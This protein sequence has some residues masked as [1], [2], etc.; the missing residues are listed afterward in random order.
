MRHCRMPALCYRRFFICGDRKRTDNGNDR[1]V[2]EGGLPRDGNLAYGNKYPL[3]LYR[4]TVVLH[5]L[6]QDVRFIEDPY[7]AYRRRKKSDMG[8]TF[9]R[10]LYNRY[11][12]LDMGSCHVHDPGSDFQVYLAGIR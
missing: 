4:Y 2:C 12:C 1:I 9:P 6:P 8:K 11:G 7:K 5:G 3:R 10:R